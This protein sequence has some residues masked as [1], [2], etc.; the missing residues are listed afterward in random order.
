MTVRLLWAQ[1]GTKK[2]QKRTA[3][4]KAQGS[5]CRFELFK[6]ERLHSHARFHDFLEFIPFIRAL[7]P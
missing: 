6:R 2:S 3:R 7:I 5:N 1:I 4:P